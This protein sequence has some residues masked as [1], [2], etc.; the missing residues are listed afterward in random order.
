MTEYAEALRATRG[1]IGA[2]ISALPEDQL[3]VPV[4]ACPHW[5]IHDLVS[6]L[7]GLAADFCGDLQVVMSPGFWAH[8]EVDR[9]EILPRRDRPTAQVFGEWV[10]LS[11]KFES[12]VAGAG[13]PLAGGIVGDYIC[14]EHDL[15][16]ALR[17]PGDRDSAECQ[18]GLDVYARSMA[19][20]V[21]AAGLPS[22]TI[23]AGDRTWTV[24]DGAAGSAVSA[25][26]FEMFRALTGRRTRDQVRAF[27]WT[28]PSD[29]YVTE[30]SMFGWPE[31]PLEE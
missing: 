17:Q 20:R 12:F 30:F 28:G 26:P 29:Q 9:R 25:E 31:A 5:S 1:R 11:P 15:R 27:G 6:H 23:W 21:K 16:G 24:G 19:V 18:L 10:A 2:L 3:H 7:A 8:D 13:S 4:P 22:L 14:H